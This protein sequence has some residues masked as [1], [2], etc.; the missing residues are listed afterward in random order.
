VAPP[1]PPPPRRRRWVGVVLAVVGIVAVLGLAVAGLA[2]FRG[3]GITATSE[4]GSPAPSGDLE[5]VVADISAFVEDERGLEFERPVEVELADDDE[6]E[7]RLL[8]DFDESRDELAET[9]LVLQGMGF[10]EPGTDLAEVL[11]TS[12]AAG[13]VG[14]YDTETDELVVRGTDTTP[15]VRTTIAHELT[16]ALD[17]QHFELDR[18]EL[19]EA[20]GEESFGF[21]ALVEGNAVRIDQRY[22]DSL[23]PAEQEDY[24]IEEAELLSTFP[25][26][27][28]PAIVIDLLSAP[29]VL[30]PPLVGTVL[31]DG[32]Q[33]ELDDAFAEPPVTSEQVMVPEKF[34]DGEGPVPVEVAP[35][36]TDGAT[37]S[38]GAFGAV[39]LALLLEQQLD[40]SAVDEAVTGWGGDGYLA[41]EQGGEA[42]VRLV[43]VG[44]TD[45]DT[46][47]LAGALSDWADEDGTA[48]AAGD[49]AGPVTV[50]RCA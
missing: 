46:A 16:H 8:E 7:R 5:E 1:P 17:D 19:D 50:E 23:T 13:V 22:F 43:V 12:L 26:F 24:S 35:R 42:C 30:G 18:P 41:W 9:E 45:G 2:V 27:T 25:A 32:G 3:D 20:D 28:I 40:P 49:G 6:F 34:L 31:D 47:E 37:E 39:L 48:T 38:S 10:I 21:D 11:E 33:D 29:Y 44:D 14:F 15:Y 4:G 36:P